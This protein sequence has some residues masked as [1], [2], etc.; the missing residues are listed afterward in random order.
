MSSSNFRSALGCFL[1]GVTVVTTID[2]KGML[3]VTANSFSSVS[4]SPPLV[5]WS[6]SK[7]S[8]KHSIMTTSKNYVIN[9]LSKNQASVAISFSKDEKPF[10]K[11]DYRLNKFG[12]PIIKKAIASFE[13]ELQTT[14]DGGDHSIIL[15]LVN[16]CNESDLEPL[17][18]FRGKFY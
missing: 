11:I 15:G 2:K 12:V 4:L 7:A 5:L 17:T 6:L 8:Q 14:Y 1:T 18:F 13:C 9:I 16:S 3:G 10:S